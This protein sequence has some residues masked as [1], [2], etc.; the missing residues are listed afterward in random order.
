M[1]SYTYENSNQSVSEEFLQECLREE[2]LGLAKLYKAFRSQDIRFISSRGIGY[3][4]N[5]SEKLWTPLYY[6]E[7]DIFAVLSNVLIPYSKNLSA[8]QKDLEKSLELEDEDSN[9]F[10]TT[11]QNCKDILQN[12]KEY[13]KARH[14]LSTSYGQRNI[15]KL[16]QADLELLDFGM[17]FAMDTNHLILPLKGK[18][19]L[20]YTSGLGVLRE[21]NRKDLCSFTI[22]VENIGDPQHPQIQRWLNTMFFKIP[23]GELSAFRSVLKRSLLGISSK[24]IIILSGP[25]STGKITLV[26]LLVKL[27]GQRIKFLSRDWRTTREM[28]PNYLSLIRMDVDRSERDLIDADCIKELLSFLSPTTTLLMTTNITDFSEWDSDLMNI[29]CTVPCE[30]SFGEQGDFPCDWDFV[31]DLHQNHLP[32]FLAWIFENEL[33]KEEMW[34]VWN[35]FNGESNYRSCIEWPPEEVMESILEILD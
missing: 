11:L 9:T 6:M 4:W 31:D 33:K 3:M 26:G 19:C 29:T 13:L 8:R 32:D 10:P 24:R 25:N 34:R 27:L 2:Y 20:D 16:L 18:M 23:P 22:E 15:V 21:R 1:I 28:R 7:K 35:R 30:T 5:S 17:E 14:I 12:R